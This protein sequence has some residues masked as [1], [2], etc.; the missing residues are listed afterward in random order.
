VPHS[1][2]LHRDEWDR[3]NT[4][5]SVEMISHFFSTC[6]FFTPCYEPTS[7]SKTLK[8]VVFRLFHPHIFQFAGGHCILQ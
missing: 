1:S 3:S 6:G 4:P 8:E 5:E 7:R 2:R